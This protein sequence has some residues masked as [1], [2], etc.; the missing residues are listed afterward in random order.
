MDFKHDLK[1]GVNIL[2]TYMEIEFS[3]FSCIP[4]SHTV[5]SIFKLTMCIY[6]WQG[7]TFFSS[8]IS[9]PNDFSFL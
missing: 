4:G 8:L 9:T 3:S 1:P 2:K 7:G 5:P 6:K